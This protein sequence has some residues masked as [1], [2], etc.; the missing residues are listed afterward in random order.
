MRDQDWTERFGADLDHLFR[1]G[2]V[3]DSDEQAPAEYAEL[4]SFAQRLSRVGFS[5]QSQVRRALSHRLLARM[6]ARKDW[7]V[8]KGLSMFALF[9]KQRYIY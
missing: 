7:H 6:D 2:K 9:Q 1:T 8:G 3:A 4:L 5:D